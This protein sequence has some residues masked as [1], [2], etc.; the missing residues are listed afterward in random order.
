M[1]IYTPLLDLRPGFFFQTA[2]HSHL[3][4]LLDTFAARHNITSN[5]NNNNNNTSLHNSTSTSL[6]YASAA[7]DPLRHQHVCH[8]QLAHNISVVSIFNYILHYWFSI[9]HAC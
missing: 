9:H 5:N 1:N 6:V 2:L 3:D 8:Q 4:Y 7:S